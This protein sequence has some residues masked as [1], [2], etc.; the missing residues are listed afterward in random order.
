MILYTPSPRIASHH[1]LSMLMVVAVTL[2]TPL[3]AQPAN[4]RNAMDAIDFLVDW[5]GYIA[6]S[7]ELRGC[8]ITH[9]DASNVLCSTGST[10]I[11]FLESDSLNRES[12]RYALY[13]CATFETGRDCLATVSGTV[14]DDDK[15]PTLINATIHWET[16]TVP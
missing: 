8:Q 4:T 6:N 13:H 14:D 9:A 15:Y 5:K 10:G 7:V 11:I 1:I 16:H 12:L 3:H 2:C